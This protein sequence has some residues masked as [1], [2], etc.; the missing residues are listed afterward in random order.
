MKQ[1]QHNRRWAFA[2]VPL[3]ATSFVLAD[4]AG[5]PKGPYPTPDSSGGNCDRH[6][7]PVICTRNRTPSGPVGCF[8]TLCDAVDFGAYRCKKAPSACEPL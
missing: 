6:A 4:L 2:A 3:L 5:Q 1:G 7:Y 8:N